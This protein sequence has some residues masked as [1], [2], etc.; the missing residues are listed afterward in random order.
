MHHEMRHRSDNSYVFWTTLYETILYIGLYELMECSEEM[1]TLDQ[2]RILF[3]S[4]WFILLPIHF[5]YPKGPA[6]E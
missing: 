2:A 6:N 5:F 1:N 3:L 4:N